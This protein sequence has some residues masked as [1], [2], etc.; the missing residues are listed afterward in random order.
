MFSEIQNCDISKQP[1][2]GNGSVN[3]PIA[4]KWL[5]SR[6]VMTG[7]DTQNNE[8]AVSLLFVPSLYAKDQLSLPVR[9][10]P[11]ARV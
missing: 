2:L 10:E 3:K 7:T 6:H 8:R 1:L 5:S 11:E 4:E 9:V